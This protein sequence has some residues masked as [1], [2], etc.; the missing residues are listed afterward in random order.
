MKI[1]LWLLK[2]WRCLCT[3][4]NMFSDTH[5]H[6][7][8]ATRERGVNGKEVLEALIARGTFFAQDIGTHCDD[9]QARYEAIEE[10]IASLD[11]DAQEKAHKMIHYSAG[12]WPAE[13]A[14]KERE[15]Q[16]KRLEDEI[17]AFEKRTG[18]KV[19][20]LG[21]C[22][23]DHHWN[24]EH[25]AEFDSDMIAAE[26]EMFE[27]QL[28]LAKKLS[29]PVI[30]HSRDAASDTIDC[31]KRVGYDKG[32]IHCYSYGIEEARIFLDR[33][34]YISFSGSITYTKKRN[35][36]DMRA[37]LR[38]VPK[39]RL[40]LE[41]DAP[42]LAP[43]PL[44]GSVNNPVNVSHTYQF[45]ADMRLEKAEE[46]SEAVDANIRALYAL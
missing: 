20:S 16:V 38:F 45:C 41:T 34:W 30:V 25:E 22:G 46:L 15:T 27:M 7:K 32:I 26:K 19:I 37:L 33:G 40:L 44:R 17:N 11:K 21:E 1:C 13:E 10:D 42:Y 3:M 24:S 9:V 5:F 35:M 29:L 12:I 43:V 18:Q 14:I 39:E 4:K 8:M 28:E 31:I 23:L 36:E 2:N 6:Y